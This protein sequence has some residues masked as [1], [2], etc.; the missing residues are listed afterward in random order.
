MWVLI[1]PWPFQDHRNSVNDL[2]D[3]F[4][5]KVPRARIFYKTVFAFSLTYSSCFFKGIYPQNW[6]FL[7]ISKKLRYITMEYDFLYIIH[8]WVISLLRLSNTVWEFLN[9]ICPVYQLAF[10]FEKI[11]LKE[12]ALVQFNYSYERMLNQ[13][14]V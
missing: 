3:I 9:C 4:R 1:T 10:F 13:I 2:S 5:G 11:S 12:L 6:T 8:L 7:C 14:E